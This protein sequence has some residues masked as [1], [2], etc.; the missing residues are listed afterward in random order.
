MGKITA[1]VPGEDYL[2]TVHFD[3]NNFVTIDMKGKLCTAR[4]SE[5]RDKQVF[6]AV[7]TDGKAVYWPGGISMSISEII[8]VVTR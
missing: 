6:G 2:V 3:N 4:F 5:L 8:E 7:K 1:V